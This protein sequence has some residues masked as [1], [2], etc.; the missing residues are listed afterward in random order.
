LSRHE[1]GND[2][3]TWEK[4]SGQQLVYFELL[5]RMVALAKP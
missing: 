1:L 5:N 4:P 2:D 3:P